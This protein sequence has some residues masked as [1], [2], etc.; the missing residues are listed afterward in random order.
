MPFGRVRG[1]KFNVESETLNGNLLI[2]RKNKGIKI[3]TED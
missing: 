1:L 3:G 2:S